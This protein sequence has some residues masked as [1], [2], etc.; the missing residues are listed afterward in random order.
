[1]IRSILFVVTTAILVFLLVKF[2]DPKAAYSG[3]RK[4]TLEISQ[5]F[6]AKIDID[7]L[8]NFE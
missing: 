6:S 7:F 8:R 1:M 2:G 5:P 3:I 4:E